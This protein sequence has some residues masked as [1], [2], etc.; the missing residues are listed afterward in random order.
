MNIKILVIAL[1]LTLFV[2]LISCNEKWSKPNTQPNIIG[3]VIGMENCH[4]DSSKNAWLISIDTKNAVLSEEIPAVSL[5]YQ[6]KEYSNVIKIYGLPKEY[7][8]NDARCMCLLEQKPYTRQEAD[9]HSTSPNVPVVSFKD[10]KCGK[11]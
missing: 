1:Q 8:R 2:N 11:K 9:C 4:S 3:D 10:I 6:G 5:I 7:Q